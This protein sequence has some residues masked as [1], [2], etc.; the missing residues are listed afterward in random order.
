MPIPSGRVWRLAFSVRAVN[1][2][3]GVL[4]AA[5]G[6]L[7]V[8]WGSTASDFVVYRVL[9]ARSRIVW[10]GR[11]HRFYQVVG[12][13]LVVLGVLWATGLIW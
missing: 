3:W 12:V 1:T 6:V 10:G 7:F 2:L 9:A 4:M 11:V 8:S 13:V 5:V